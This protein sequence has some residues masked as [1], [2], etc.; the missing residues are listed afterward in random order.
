MNYQEKMKDA[1]EMAETAEKIFERL[2]TTVFAC[3]EDAVKVTLKILELTYG[4][5]G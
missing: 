2:F 1:L 4:K 3:R 5:E